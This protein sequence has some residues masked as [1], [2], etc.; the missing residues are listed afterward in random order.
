MF[1]VVH[2]SD[3]HVFHAEAAWRAPD[4]FSKRLTGWMNLK[5]TPRGKQFRETLHVLRR[6]VDDIHARKPDLL[7]FT[8]DATSLGVEEEFA[9]AAEVLRVGAAD[10]PPGL[11]VPGN[12]D[13]YTRR[14]VHEGLFE[15]YFAPWLVGD[16]VS[17]HIYPFGRR[18]GP[19]YLLGV[20]SSRPTRWMWDSSGHVGPQQLKRLQELLARPNVQELPKILVTHYPIALPCGRP[21][22]RHRR[23]RDL[24]ALLEVVQNHGVNLWLHGHRHN[25]YHLEPTPEQP[26]PALCVGS[27]TMRDHW[28]Y[29]EYTF[30]GKKL[31]IEYRA[32]QPRPAHFET[33]RHL[34]VPLV[35]S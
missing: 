19:L 5:Y 32:F 15:K 11:A 4:W 14:S 2:F 17:E 22:K 33:V 16:R 3:I 8:G 1:R 18:E 29:A 30:D 9:L 28:T 25:A 13:Y 20:N 10:S 34:E 26:V 6:L 24:P 7:L 31:F 35:L 21:E 27:G 23:L 12:H